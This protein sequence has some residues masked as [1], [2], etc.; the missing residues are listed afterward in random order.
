M[1]MASSNYRRVSRKRACRV[2]GKS[3]WCSFTPDEKISFC[4]RI[5]ENA[6]RVSRTG[7]GVFYHEK[8][9]LAGE[10]FRFP[11]KPPRRKAELAPIEIRDF[12][13]R[14]LIELSPAHQSNEIIDG[15]KGLRARRILD[16]E[17]YG[18]LPQS[19]SERRD[20]AKQI[21]QLIN[22]KFPD[23]VRWQKSGVAGLP[24]FWLG[25]RGQVQLWLDRDY[26][27][28]LML[29]PYRDENGLIQACQIRYM[30]R[31]APDKGVR[32]VWLSTPDKANGVS[33]GS[34]VHF[35]RYDTAALNKPILITEGALKAD[36]MR[37]FKTDCDVLA[38]AGVNCSHEELVKA[39]RYRSVFIAF[40]IDSYENSH[41]ARATGRLIDSLFA[42]AAQ[43][44]FQPRIKILTWD[45][46]FKGID[47]ALLHNVPIIPLLPLEWRKSLNADCRSQIE[48]VCPMAE[49]SLFRVVRHGTI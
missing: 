49:Y 32:Y 2:C 34:P 29:I 31:T 1:F 40:D 23:Y 4:A 11:S 19:R 5:V 21:R 42:E 10:P 22:R 14:K 43:S 20:L 33:C 18:S 3:D 16:F 38:S 15:P 25:K 13:Y 48:Q 46:K 17:N 12:A 24:G 37:F 27:F 8:S 26:S 45:T 41:V 6:T 47:E 36:T 7:W 44:G 30:C 35:A 39:A 9:L 28:P